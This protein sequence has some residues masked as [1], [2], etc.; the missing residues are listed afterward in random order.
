MISPL[1]YAVTSRIRVV[2]ESLLIISPKISIIFIKMD[3]SLFFTF[4]IG[5]FDEQ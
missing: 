2:K 1:G 4:Q 3:I 5:L